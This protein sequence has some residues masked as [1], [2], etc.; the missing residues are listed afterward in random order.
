MNNTTHT[1][2]T[3]NKKRYTFRE[4]LENLAQ[5]ALAFV[6]V[7][8]FLCGLG[9]LCSSPQDN[10]PWLLYKGM[11]LLMFAI[12]MLAM[13]VLGRI[14]PNTKHYRCTKCDVIHIPDYGTN[15]KLLTRCPVC[16]KRTVF[17]RI[18]ENT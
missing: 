14:I 8:G 1:I 12:G 13:Q 10:E 3:T 17:K 9:F 15:K 11:G 6:V 2:E 5:G 4:V 16:N 18:E 7:M